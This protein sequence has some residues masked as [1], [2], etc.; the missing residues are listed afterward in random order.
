M[1]KDSRRAMETVGS[2]RG[3]AGVL[4][5]QVSRTRSSPD[6]TISPSH[7]DTV[8]NARKQKVGCD[9]AGVEGLR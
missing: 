4:L 6:H 9:L 1:V 8:H 7:G 2:G 3:E 5:A